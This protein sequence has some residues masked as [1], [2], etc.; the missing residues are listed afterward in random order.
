[1]I[2]QIDLGKLFI[3]KIIRLLKYIEFHMKVRY[4]KKIE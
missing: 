3:R 1:M 2:Q 4:E